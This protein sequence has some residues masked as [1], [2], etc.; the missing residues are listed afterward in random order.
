MREQEALI[1]I[2]VQ[3]DFCTGG[4]LSVPGGEQIIPAVNRIMPDFSFVAAT[5]D[6][7]PADHFS[8]ASTHPGK[9]PFD[10]VPFGDEAQTLWPDHCVIGTY[11][12]QLHGNLHTDLIDVIIRKGKDPALDSYSAFF[13]NDHITATGLGGLLKERGVRALTLC[14]LATDIC[15]Y[16]SALDAL[17]LGFEVYLF[18]EG[19]KGLDAPAGTLDLRIRELQ[20][21]GVTIC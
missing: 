14:G 1:I 9:S 10:T 20:A 3:N 12:A 19:S 17:R 18:M 6:W 2:D 8:F 15:V 4:A 7:H 21:Q 16:F 13:E 5:Q 11:G